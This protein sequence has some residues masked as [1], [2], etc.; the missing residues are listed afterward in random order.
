MLEIMRFEPRDQR[1]IYAVGSNSDKVHVLEIDL[2]A[3]DR[4]QNSFRKSKDEIKYSD[5]ITQVYIQ[6]FSP[7]NGD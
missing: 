3:T 6:I 1:S 5:A 7:K 4:S 2:P